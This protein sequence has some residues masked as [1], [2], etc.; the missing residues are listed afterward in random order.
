MKSNL[1]IVRCLQETFYFHMPTRKVPFSK[2]VEVFTKIWFRFSK[3]RAWDKKKTKASFKRRAT[4]THTK[5]RTLNFDLRI[6]STRRL[7]PLVAVL[8]GHGNQIRQCQGRGG[9]GAGGCATR[10]MVQKDAPHS[11]H[12]KMILLRML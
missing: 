6:A 2:F 4:V 10:G 12:M 9:A 8:V 1:L 3:P 7:K 5:F 11:I